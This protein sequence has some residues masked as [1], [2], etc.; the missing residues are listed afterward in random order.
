MEW[1]IEEQEELPNNAGCLVAA[2]DVDPDGRS[3]R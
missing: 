1:H 3:C 2:L